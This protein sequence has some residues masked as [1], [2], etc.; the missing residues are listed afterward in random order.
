MGR[1]TVWGIDLDYLDIEWFALEMNRDH[2]VVFVSALSTMEKFQCNQL[3]TRWLLITLSNGA[4]LAAGW[5]WGMSGAGAG[6]CCWQ[7]RH[8][9]IALAR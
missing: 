3:A 5:G 2:S 8:S 6:L 7:I 1:V 4:L 9:V